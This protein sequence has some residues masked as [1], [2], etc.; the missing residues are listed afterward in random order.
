MF[1]K[2]KKKASPLLSK[3]HVPG[4]GHFFMANSLLLFANRYVSIVSARSDTNPDSED[5]LGGPGVKGKSEQVGQALGH[6][7]QQSNSLPQ[8]NP[9]VSIFLPQRQTVYRMKYDVSRTA[10]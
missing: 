9:P 2:K 7:I 6:Y 4:T 10:S 5:F 3:K 1:Q 8:D